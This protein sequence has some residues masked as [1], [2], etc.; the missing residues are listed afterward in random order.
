MLEKIKC[1]ITRTMEIVGGKWTLPIIYVLQS[2][3]KRFKDLERSIEGIN[4]RMLVKE[5]KAL[6]QNNIV[7]RKVYA[8]V[9]PKVEY[10][11]T[12]KGRAL[13]TVLEEMKRWGKT[14]IEL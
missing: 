5:L 9:P 3:T 1:P 14:Y 10:S 11:L 6:E 7:E 2:G 8:E 12:D 4:T 13:K